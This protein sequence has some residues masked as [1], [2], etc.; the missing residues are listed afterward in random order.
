[1]QSS[2]IPIQEVLGNF[3]GLFSSGIL[4]SK[5]LVAYNIRSSGR[6]L[7]VVDD[8]INDILAIFW[9]ATVVFIVCYA[10]RRPGCVCA[11]H[12]FPCPLAVSSS[13][14]HIYSGG[15]FD[16][17]L[18]DANNFRSDTYHTILSQSIAA[19][20]QVILDG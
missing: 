9:G 18:H 5:F 15:I 3:F 12:Y 2:P 14:H 13:S 7:E 16:S 20:F 4:L 6:F 8:T 11:C 1:M 17:V 10:R 19:K